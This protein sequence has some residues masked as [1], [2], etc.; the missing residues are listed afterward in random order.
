MINTDYTIR[1]MSPD[2]VGLVLDWAADE[3][4]NPG[5]NDA[6]CFYAA[7]PEGFLVGVLDGEPVASRARSIRRRSP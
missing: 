3:G 6:D 7:D 5:L 2:E 4:W 1:S